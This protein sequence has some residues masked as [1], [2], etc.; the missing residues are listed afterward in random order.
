LREKVIPIL[1]DAAHEIDKNLKGVATRVLMPLP[2]KARD[3]VDA[4]VSS[5]ANGTGMIHY[6]CHV[7]ADNRKDAL[8]SGRINTLESFSK[9]NHSIKNIRVVREV[10]PRFYQI[11]SDVH[12]T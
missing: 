9:F 6:F 8:E 12:V 10:G 1:G 4:A 3:F 11:V 2:E 7:G 5:L